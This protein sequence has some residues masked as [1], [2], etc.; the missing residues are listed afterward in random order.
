MILR[1]SKTRA[2]I[3]LQVLLFMLTTKHKYCLRLLET[4]GQFESRCTNTGHFR[5]VSKTWIRQ[6]QIQNIP[7]VRPVAQSNS[8]I[9]EWTS[10]W[11]LYWKGS[12][13]N[14]RFNSILV[15]IWFIFALYL[16]YDWFIFD[17]YSLYIWFI[18][19]LYLGYI[20]FVFRLYLAYI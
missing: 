1:N 16:V 18:I 19:G 13:R 5:H 6:K 17:L 14:C 15:Y 20:W 10:D 9:K 7:T 2:L 4:G 11:L 8:K 12:N 3:T